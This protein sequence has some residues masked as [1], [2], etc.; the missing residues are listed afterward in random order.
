MSAPL[1]VSHFLIEILVP[2]YLSF[3]L[4]RHSNSAGLNQPPDIVSDCWRKAPGLWRIGFDQFNRQ[5]PVAQAANIFLQSEFVLGENF[6]AFGA[7]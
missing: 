2:C 7:A 3:S 1:L 6:D 5:F 4:L